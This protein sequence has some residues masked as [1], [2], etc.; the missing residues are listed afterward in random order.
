MNVKFKSENTK[1]ISDGDEYFEDEKTHCTYKMPVT[2]E[3]LLQF[4][5]SIALI[6]SCNDEDD[7]FNPI[8]IQDS[9]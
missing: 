1:L 5:D 9:V 6:K 2:T 7:F 4:D 8:T 3:D